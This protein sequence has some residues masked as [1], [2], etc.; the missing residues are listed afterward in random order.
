MKK[1]YSL[2]IAVLLI[3][4]NISAQTNHLVNAGNYYYTPANLTINAGDTVTWYNDGGF[5]D[6]N[7]DINSQTGSSFGNPSSFYIPAVSGPAPLGYM[8]LLLLVI[9]NMIVLLVSMLQMEWL[10][11]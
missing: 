1:L 2:L 3:Q 8:Y 5:H 11:T 4:L 6:V 9:M 10:D 7:G